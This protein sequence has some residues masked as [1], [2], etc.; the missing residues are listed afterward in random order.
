MD[1]ESKFRDWAK[2]PGTTEEQKCSNAENAIRNA[3]KASDKLRDRDIKIFSQ[4]S[5]RNNTNVRKNSDVDI[6]IICYNTFFYNLPDGSNSSDFSI[7]PATYHFSQ[8]K[9]EVEEALRSYFR[10]G[11]VTRGNKAFDVHETSYHVEADVTPFFEHRRFNTDGSF[12][13][14]VELQA[15]NGG[16]VINWPEQHYQNG[17]TKNNNTGRRFK[18][19]VRVLKALCS[20]IESNAANSTPGFLIECLVWHA[21]NGHFGSQLYRTDLRNILIFLY[22]KLGQDESDDWGEVSELKYLFG[23]HQKWTKDQARNFVVGAWD[24]ASLGDES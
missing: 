13:S 2:P 18:A 10:Q 22:D 15:D 6:G 24:Y 9:N 4:G 20:E 7:A 23:N 12:L 5:Y 21:P 3:I 16:T 14:G 19:M 17:V 8:F 11:S 1:W